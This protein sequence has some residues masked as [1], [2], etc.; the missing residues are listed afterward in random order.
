MK[1]VYIV[2]IFMYICVMKTHTVYALINPMNGNPFYVGE[3]TDLYNRISKHLGCKDKHN[4][5]KNNF[6]KSL[7]DTGV[8]PNIEILEYDI[9]SKEVAEKIESEF[10]LKYKLKCFVLF[11]KNN[12]GNKPPLQIANRTKEQK[13]NAVKCSPQRKTVL[14]YT[15]NMEF[16]KEFI[17]V[18]EACRETNIDHRSISQVASGSTTR[19]TAGGFKWI[20]K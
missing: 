3:T 5:E 20:Y 11:N 6:I 8:K 2:I 1:Y 14:Q 15:K 16:V 18:R 9:D 12:G 19:K 17:G 4:Y 7:L 10:I 13:E